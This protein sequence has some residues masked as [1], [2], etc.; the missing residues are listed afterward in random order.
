V[1]DTISPLKKLEAAL[2]DTGGVYVNSGVDPAEY[3]ERLAASIRKHQCDPFLVSA[4][5][6]E[7]GFP[8]AAV[9]SNISGQCVAHSSGYWLVYQ[10]QQDRFYCFWG[11]DPS[12]LGAHGVIGSPLYCWSA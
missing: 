12:N 10:P 9:G 1:Q 3:F 11:Q 7:P 8:D 4:V 2:S 6:Q 5:V